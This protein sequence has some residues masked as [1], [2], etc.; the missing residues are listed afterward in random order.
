MLK[1]FFF[2]LSNMIKVEIQ[3][4]SHVEVFVDIPRVS[5]VCGHT[6][7]RG[8]DILLLQSLKQTLLKCLWRPP[9]ASGL[10]PLYMLQTRVKRE[11]SA[12]F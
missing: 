11:A 1:D 3:Q 10:G 7:N 9:Q 2:F 12:S 4:E 6:W 8:R 5:V